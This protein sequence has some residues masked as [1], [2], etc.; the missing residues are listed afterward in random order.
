MAKFRWN[1]GKREVLEALADAAEMAQKRSLRFPFK[2]WARLLGCCENTVRNE[3][4]RGLCR[5][6]SEEKGFYYVYDA[7]IAEEKAKT[8]ARRQ[9][10]KSLL[11]RR[12]RNKDFAAA[13]IYLC[14]LLLRKKTHKRKAGFYSVEA[15]WR[16]TC[17]KFPEWRVCLA[18]VWNWI[19]RGE[20]EERGITLDTVRL[21]KR[22]TRKVKRS[23]DIEAWSRRHAG[24]T[25]WDRPPEV[26]ALTRPMDL[27]A[28]L[29]K[30]IQGDGTSIFSLISRSTQRQWC[31]LISRPTQRCVHGALRRLVDEMKRE[32]LYIDTVT[33]DNGIEF[34]D[35]ARLEEIAAAGRKDGATRIFYAEPY[36]SGQRGRNEH[37]HAMLRRY[38][39]QSLKHLTASSLAEIT[40]FVNAYPRP[41]FDGLSA[42]EEFA[43]QIGG[44]APRPPPGKD[45]ASRLQIVQSLL[46]LL[47]IFV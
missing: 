47:Q 29:M 9:G 10:N 45:E 13:L 11:V 35:T 46:A 1:G 6:G 14:G 17:R 28:D 41:I 8:A 5:M 44:G 19:K 18:T 30:S 24:R 40:A 4:H 2:E 21:W 26:D 3:I 39:G 20:L 42:D 12:R 38:T 31:V 23:R 37:N 27:E 15:C 34:A 33:F 7:A 25:I 16:L 43:R 36:R 32:G 22:R